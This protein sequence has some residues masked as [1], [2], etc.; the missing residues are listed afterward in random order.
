MLYSRLHVLEL[1]AA[2]GEIIELIE[3]MTQEKAERANGDLLTCIYNLA[4]L[5]NR[6]RV[7]PEI[8]QKVKKLN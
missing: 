2:Q 4:K 5:K 7:L 6:P 8:F 1:I 3:A